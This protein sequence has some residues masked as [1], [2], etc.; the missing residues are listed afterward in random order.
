MTPPVDLL[1][2]LE[3][4]LSKIREAPTYRAISGAVA[5]GGEFVQTTRELIEAIGSECIEEIT[6]LRGERDRLMAERQ[7]FK[8]LVDGALDRG[9][10]LEPV[11]PGLLDLARRLG[12]RRPPPAPLRL[13]VGEKIK[14]EVVLPSGYGLNGGEQLEARVSSVRRSE[15]IRDP[16]TGNDAVRFTLEFVAPLPPNSMEG[17]LVVPPEL[18]P[19][20]PVQGGPWVVLSRAGEHPPIAIENT[21]STQPRC[22]GQMIM[23]SGLRVVTFTC[24]REYDHAGDC[25]FPLPEPSEGVVRHG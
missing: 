21:T 6:K 24:V 16:R 22:P 14:L 19:Q 10:P 20:L 12:F 17:A 13:W 18:A 2:R 4:F 11:T 9:V 7:P 15:R 1:E 23:P 5:A 25:M 3:M 8:T